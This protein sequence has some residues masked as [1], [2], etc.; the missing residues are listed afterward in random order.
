M[1]QFVRTRRESRGGDLPRTDRGGMEAVH[2]SASALPSGEGQTF[3]GTLVRTLCAVQ[4]RLARDSTLT[5]GTVQA[6]LYHVTGIVGNNAVPTGA[7]LASSEIIDI[8]TITDGSAEW[9]RFCFYGDQMY[10]MQAGVDYAIVL[11]IRSLIGVGG[12]NAY[13]T[14]GDGS[15]HVGNE[16]QY[17]NSAWSARSAYDVCFRIEVNV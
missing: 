3:I 17:T 14:V 10:E 16:V 11:E 15:A 2:P 4:F 13:A 7:P 8:S 12:L 6:V 1:W 9:V 5:G